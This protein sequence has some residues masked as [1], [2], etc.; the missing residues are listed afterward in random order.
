MWS[1]LGSCD[2]GPVNR[3]VEGWTRSAWNGLHRRT[4]ASPSPT[5]WAWAADVTLA[6]AMVFS[7]LNSGYH[8]AMPI[9][10]QHGPFYSVNHLIVVGPRDSFL[11]VMTA[12]PLMVRRRFPLAA[13][14]S[15]ELAVMALHANVTDANDTAIFTFMSILI[16]AYSA[17]IYSPYRSAMVYSLAVGAI[18]LAATRGGELPNVTRGFVPFLFLIPIVLGAN[19]I[20]NWRQRV[21]DLEEQSESA[22][23]RAVEQERARIAAELHDVV[24]HNVSVM[25]VQAGAARK[26]LDKS[27]DLAREA[28]LAVEDSG[29]AAMAELRHVM[30][31]LTMTSQGGDPAGSADLA[32]QPGLEQIPALVERIRNGGVRVDLAIEGDVI[33]LPSGLDLAA[34]RVVQEALT[35][36][37]KHAVGALIRVTLDYSPQRLKVDVVDTGGSAS[38]SAATGNGRGLAGLRQRL[39][40][41]GGTLSAG[42]RLTGGYMVSAVIPLR[43]GV[44]A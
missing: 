14:W 19:A 17:A 36:A 31:L 21:E 27:P 10:D 32:P 12:L 15:C 4:G 7:T 2:T 35:N 9:P 38:S 26:V 25:V 3:D 24:S 5:R 44:A 16:A 11:V 1:G 28:L 40:V 18:L 41:Y 22:T 20:G 42:P 29:R 37:V 13:F 43:E 34:Y 30:G 33:P 6:M 23:L 39:A 8:H